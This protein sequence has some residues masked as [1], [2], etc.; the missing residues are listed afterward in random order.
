M[1]PILKLALF[2]PHEV[3]LYLVVQTMTLL[4]RN[5]RKE[6][7][8]SHATRHESHLHFH[9]HPGRSG[10]GGRSSTTPPTSL[11]ES[12]YR[13]DYSIIN[14]LWQLLNDWEEEVLGSFVASCRTSGHHNHYWVVKNLLSLTL[15]NFQGVFFHSP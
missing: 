10:R 11:L 9:P 7:F 2:S 13:Y 6:S 12:E 3:Y 8:I 1:T 15:L 14:S 4:P 5:A